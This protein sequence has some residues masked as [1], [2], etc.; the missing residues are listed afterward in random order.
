MHFILIFRRLS[1]RGKHFFKW[2]N[3]QELSSVCHLQPTQVLLHSV[4]G[5]DVKECV[6]GSYQASFCNLSKV[7]DV[8][9][10]LFLKCSN[11]IINIIN[12]SS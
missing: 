6:H 12:S 4:G 9:L 3:H 8:I 7:L 10:A 1:R 5:H 11:I 2:A